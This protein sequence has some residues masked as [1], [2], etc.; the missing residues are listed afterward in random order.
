MSIAAIIVAAGSSQRMGFDKLA[1]D[2]R[3]RPVLAHSVEAFSASPSIDEI[4]V[5]C[6]AQRFE[7]LLPGPF[8]KPIHRVDGGATRQESVYNG[9][10]AL[11]AETT[12]VAVHDG[13]RPLIHPSE[14]EAC[15]EQARKYGASALGR[16]VAETLKRADHE[17]FA[18]SSVEREGLWF[19]E[20]PQCFRVNALK[21]AYQQ[22]RERH[23]VVTDEVS[24]M[25]ATGISSYLVESKAP[26]L[27]IT[28]P[29]DLKLAAYLMDVVEETR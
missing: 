4:F 27:K 8:A 16:R 25:E 5:V 21:R 20:T 28:L 11:Y 2:L 14:I 26:N 24:A 13:A 9:L 15:L 3:G 22:V 23:L 12:I 10:K 19:M 29:A 6:S 18:R 17:G 1:A 7:E